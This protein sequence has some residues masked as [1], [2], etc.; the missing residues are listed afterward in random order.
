MHSALT[1]L[2]LLYNLS[3]SFIRS[4]ADELQLNSILKYI[5]QH[6]ADREAWDMADKGMNVKFTQ[7]K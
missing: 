2:S 5:R 1:L 6:A 3:C 7:N 4:K